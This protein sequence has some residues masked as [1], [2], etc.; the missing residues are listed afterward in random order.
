M[1]AREYRYGS[2]RRALS[3]QP[4]SLSGFLLSM[5]A[6]HLAATGSMVSSTFHHS[7]LTK[8]PV[9]IMVWL[10]HHYYAIVG[11]AGSTFHR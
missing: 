9:G 3:E 6:A 2:E 7:L 11:A 1:C 8:M 5:L 4:D 10:E